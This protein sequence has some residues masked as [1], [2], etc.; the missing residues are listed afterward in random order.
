M[1]KI[2]GK[3]QT[4]YQ[5]CSDYG[6]LCNTYVCTHGDVAK[7]PGVQEIMSLLCVINAKLDRPEFGIVLQTAIENQSKSK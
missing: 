7:S 5:L 4:C 2:D 1:T 3:N 6:A